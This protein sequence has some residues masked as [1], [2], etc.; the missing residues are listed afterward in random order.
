MDRDVPTPVLAKA[1][2][3]LFISRGLTLATAESLTGGA[4]ASSLVDVPGTS[5]VF[6]GGA[7]TYAA[8]T[9]ASVLDV[10]PIRLAEFGPVDPVVAQQMAVRVAEKFGA[11]V[12][13]S[14]TGV[15]GPGP[16]DGHPAGT[17]WIAF[18]FDGAV[19]F[20]EKFALSGDR[21]AV[22]A[23]TIQTALSALFTE[24]SIVKE[25]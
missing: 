15:A 14:T 16:A 24:F 6:R 22:R 13:I 9:K 17:V 18:S 2:V 19:V 21:N 8:D 5:Q 10:D 3:E 20:C 12:G 1:V 4:L 25:F 23:G 11:N 7:V